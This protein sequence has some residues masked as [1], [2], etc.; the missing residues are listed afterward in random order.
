MRRRSAQREID[1]DVPRETKGPAQ[2]DLG[3]IPLVRMIGPGRHGYA[4]AVRIVIAD[5]VVDRDIP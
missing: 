2:I 1:A 3:M 4:Q 5:R